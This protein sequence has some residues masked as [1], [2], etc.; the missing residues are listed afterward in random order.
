MRRLTIVTDAWHPQ[1]SGVVTTLVATIKVLESRGWKVTIIHPGLF[2]SFPLPGYSEI[3]IPVFFKSKARRLLAESDPDFIHISTEGRLG[4]FVRGLC[5]KAGVRFTTTYH[6]AFPEMIEARIGIPASWIYP[7]LR[8]FHNASASMHVATL[9]LAE[10]LASKG[11]AVPMP[12][13]SRG[14]DTDKFT[15]NNRDVSIPGYAL[16]VGRVS[17]EKNI[18]AF[19]EA[20]CDLRKVVVGSG[21][22]LN[23]LKAKYPEV[24]FTGR[25]SGK[26][27]GVLYAS[28]EVFVFPS[29]ADTFGLVLIE[30]M[31]S[32]TPIAAF[33]A[34]NCQA[35]VTDEVGCL[36]D[37]LGVAIA[38][39]RN[40]ERKTCAVNARARYSWEAATDQFAS[41]LVIAVSELE[42]ISLKY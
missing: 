17:H 35:I 28:A 3:S 36:D 11:I 16:Y 40:K 31:A 13:W 12:I 15:P 30:A 37:D 33:P 6:T 41:G 7:V 32:G 26:E 10:H 23:E 9:A 34:E 25:K 5:I 8:S 39:A 20:P 18:E 2:A 14:I 22:Q 4:W 1:V 38:V 19:L 29:Y 24:E 42:N 27:L 21:P